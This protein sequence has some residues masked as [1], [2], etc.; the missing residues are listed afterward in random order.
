MN[1]YL[2]DLDETLVNVGHIHKKAY[3]EMMS[4]VYSHAGR[5]ED[6]KG[7]G[8]TSHNILYDML[9]HM[10]KEEVDA[11]KA[12]AEKHLV[13]ALERDVNEEHVFPKIKELLSSLA[14]SH[15]VALFTGGAE[16]ITSTILEKT[17]LKGYFEFAISANPGE[18]RQDVLARAI[19]EAKSRWQIE[20]VFVVGDTNHDVTA[21][22]AN[23]VISVAVGTGTQ[24]RE[25]VLAENPDMFFENLQDV[26]KVLEAIG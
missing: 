7:P 9:A 21:A 2:F 6:G 14:K 13:E 10:S 17:K 22:R 26:D 3:E 12:D 16:P 19:A 1:L 4:K 25:V 18:E 24:A 15:K 23:K 5:F 11:R 20:K 8:R